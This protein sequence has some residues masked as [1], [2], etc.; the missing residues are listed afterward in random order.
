MKL[1]SLLTL[2]TIIVLLSNNYC[3]TSLINTNC[4][5]LN[6]KNE[7]KIRYTLIADIFYLSNQNN[8]SDKNNQSTLSLRVVNGFQFYKRLTLGVGI[9]SEVNT[10]PVSFS[11]DLR[12]SPKRDNIAPI[13][14]LN[15]G[16]DIFNKETGIRIN[17]TFGIKKYLT[18]TTAFHLNF[19]IYWYESNIITTSSWSTNSWGNNTSTSYYNNIKKVSNVFLSIGGGLSF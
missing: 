17:P 9:A 6:L 13:L 7:K 15:I 16:K 18:E 2:V 5:Y 14:G 12:Y 4:N 11:M 1:K 3:Q 10:I 19:G 8:S